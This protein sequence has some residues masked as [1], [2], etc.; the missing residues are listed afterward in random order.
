[1]TKRG[2]S[3][4]NATLIKMEANYGSIATDSPPDNRNVFSDGL[5]RV[6]FVLVWEESDNPRKAELNF[7]PSH[8]EWREEFIKKLKDSGLLT[9]QREVSQSD[10][11]IYFVL[12]S[13]PWSTLCY[14]AEEINLRVPLQVVHSPFRNVS[15]RLLSKLSIPN[16]LSQDVPN[17]PTHYYTCHFRSTKLDRFLG[18]ENRDTFFKITQRHRVLYEIL[19]KTPYGSVTKGEVGIDRLVNEKVFTAAYPLHEGDVEAPVQ[20]GALRQTLYSYW[21]QWS[22]WTRY[23]PMDHIREYF[24]EKIALYFA[25]LGVYTS[26]LS[27]ASIVGLLI[28][29]VGFYFMKTDVP[30]ME[31]CSSGNTFIMCPICN[32][33][34]YWNY[35]SI[36]GSYKAG[37]LFDNPGTVFLSVFISLWAVSFLESWKR[38]SF[39]LSHRWDCSDFQDIEEQPRPEFTAMAPMTTRN[40]VTGVEEPYFP[41]NKR[42]RRTLTSCMVIV[43]MVIVVLMFLIAV[44]L[45]RTILSIII[46]RS[47]VKFISPSAKIIASITGSVMNLLVILML[48]KVYTALAHILTRWEMHRTQSKYEDMF[49]LKVFV[50]Q[51]VNFYSSTVYVAFFK[52]RFIGYPGNY[53]SLFGVRNEDCGAGGCLME[54]A[55]ELLIIMVGKQLIN[56]VQELIIPKLTS[57]FQRKKLNALDLEAEQEMLPWEKDYLLVVSEGLCYEYL[58]MVIQYGFITIFVA[59]CP[60]APLFALFNNWIEI[61][62]DANKFVKEY[63]RPVVERAQNIGIWFPIL[64][65]I[66]HAAV[67]SNAFIIAFTSS[68]IPRL[69]YKYTRDASMSGYINFTLATSPRSFALE[70]HIAPCRYRGFRDQ[71]GHLLPEY[72]HLLALRLTFIIVFEHVVFAIGRLIDLSVA[73]VPEEVSLKI[74][75]EH[76]MAKEALAENQSLVK[77]MVPDEEEEADVSAQTPSSP[78]A[79]EDE[80]QS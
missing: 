51:F 36:C 74:K 61:R 48:S 46:H 41:E 54:L 15:E 6:D 1:M 10:K 80:E 5:S 2:E 68:F 77:T 50:F 28:F 20:S 49:I 35:S 60:L 58:E 53:Y 43:M 12:L 14:Y 33:C 40:P 23:Q 79:A 70:Q 27:L 25:W 55:Q 72:F 32:I 18:S 52:G 31:V 57:W 59:A 16:L 7:Y 63:R 38:T 29:L 26:W 73:D 22:C 66:T 76:Y 39:T 8:S 69:Y 47:G 75:R 19:A 21:S 42:L 78:A 24:G 62:L 56:N 9:E 34:T 13:A 65:F 44:I 17:P 30:V 37:L 4:D 3:D 67:L 11:R 45:Y 71:D 64:Q